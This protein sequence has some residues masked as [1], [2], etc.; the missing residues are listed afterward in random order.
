MRKLILA[1]LIAAILIMAMPFIVQVR[2]IGGDVK[3]LSNVEVNELMKKM[4]IGW[5]DPS[6][7]YPEQSFNY[8]VLD[9]DGNLIYK[10]GIGAETIGR[11][12]EERDV[13]RDIT[14]GD[15]VVGKLIIYSELDNIQDKMERTLLKKY[16]ILAGGVLALLLLVLLLVEIKVIRPFDKLKEFASAVAA[17]DLDKPLEMDRENIFGA[18]TEGFDIMRER[19]NES[20]ERELQMS[21]SKKELIAQLSH[22]IKTPVASIKAMSEVLG[23]KEDRPAVK[24]KLD[25][26]GLKADQIDGLVSNLFVSTL[27]ELNRLEVKE[28]D[29][30]SVELEK[31]IRQADYN[32]R[33]KEMEIPECVIICDR[34]RINQVISNIIFNSYKYADTD[35]YVSGI[36]DVDFLTVSI[37]DRGGGIPVE[38]LNLI[39]KKYK[40][41]SNA[42]TKQG[43]GLGLFISKELMENMQG[44]LEVTNADGGLR[45]NIS[46]KLA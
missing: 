16:L 27:N 45:V 24:E 20:R 39:T 26:I 35:I 15:E 8:A 32:N 9:M 41:G 33:I 18:F 6:F 30:E 4:E 12:T 36:T 3:G 25:S 44:G 1:F 29:M 10:C 31:Y 43:A 40:R 13:I 37:T 42:D 34:L 2:K 11:A 21:I 5:N 19:L 17:G 28:S 38:E 23:A 22:D 14:V 46:F 7:V